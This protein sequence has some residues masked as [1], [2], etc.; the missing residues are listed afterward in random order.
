M[1]E[2]RLAGGNEGAV[3][4]RVKG[5]PKTHLMP[6]EFHE[7]SH[8]YETLAEAALEHFRAGNVL[9]ARFFAFG[10]VDVFGDD[11]AVEDGGME[12]HAREGFAE[13]VA[14]DEGPED[15][16]DGQGCDQADDES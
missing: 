4:Q 3:R 7:L 13:L 5:R 15:P 12:H 14:G 10:V 9:G 2:E 6:R 11:A 16:V 8:A 1:F